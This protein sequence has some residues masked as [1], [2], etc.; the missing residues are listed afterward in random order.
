MN[1]KGSNIRIL[2]KRPT[3]AN[4]TLQYIEYDTLRKQVQWGIIKNLGFLTQF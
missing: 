2:L 1:K 4:F 3:K